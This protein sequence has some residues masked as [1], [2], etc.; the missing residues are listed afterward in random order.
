MNLLL[1]NCHFTLMQSNVLL[2]TPALDLQI[3]LLCDPES[4][5]CSTPMLHQPHG[6]GNLEGHVH[7]WTK[8]S[9]MYSCMA[10]DFAMCRPQSA[11]AVLGGGN[12]GS[13]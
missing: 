10:L 5:I 6:L 7:R 13:N 11:T 12:A 2:S 3:F 4:E 9:G 8:S 1:W